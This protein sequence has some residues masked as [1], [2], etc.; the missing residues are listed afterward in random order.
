MVMIWKKFRITI[1][2]KPKVQRRNAGSMNQ[3]PPTIIVFPANTM[4]L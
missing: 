1:G 4:A 3:T 2:R